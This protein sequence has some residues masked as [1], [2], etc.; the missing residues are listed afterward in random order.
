MHRVPN[1]TYVNLNPF[2]LLTSHPCISCSGRRYLPHTTSSTR[3]FRST[4]PK[5]HSPGSSVPRRSRSGTLD[6]VAVRSVTDNYRAAE[7]WCTSTSQRKVTLFHK[8]VAH[9]LFCFYQR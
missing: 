3:C 7:D 4:D 6:E 2:L 1:M 8:G 5:V 9:K